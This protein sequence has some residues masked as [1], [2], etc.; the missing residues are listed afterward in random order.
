MKTPMS[1]RKNKNY[2][3]NSFYSLFLFFL[4]ILIFPVLFLI[5][6]LYSIFI[7]IFSNIFIRIK[8]YIIL[9]WGFAYSILLSNKNYNISFIPSGGD[10]VIGY[11]V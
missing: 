10:D 11:S 2:D 7:L 9:L 3:N 1:S 6:P 8:T 4:N 5:N